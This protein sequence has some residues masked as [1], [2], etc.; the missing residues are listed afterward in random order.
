MTKAQLRRRVMQK[1]MVLE[2]G[3]TISA[4][5]AEDVDAII[6]SVHGNLQSRNKVSWDVENIPAYAETAMIDLVAYEAA[7]SF[8]KQGDEA[9]RTKGMK[10]INLFAQRNNNCNSVT[11]FSDF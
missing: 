4:E 7:P 10:T 8:G 3:E 1:L 9:R 2:A 11:E 5:D 6:D